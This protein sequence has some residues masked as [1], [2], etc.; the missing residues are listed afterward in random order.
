MGYASDGYERG[1]PF[2]SYLKESDIYLSQVQ[3]IFDRR[4]AVCHSCFE[5][6]CQLKL[7]S[8]DMLIRGANSHLPTG[9]LL[10]AAPRTDLMVTLEQQ[11]RGGFYSVTEG[12]SNSILVNVL[13][14]GNDKSNL[15][16]EKYVKPE[17]RMCVTSVDAF[18]KLDLQKQKSLG[19]PYYMAALSSSELKILMAWASSGS[20]TPSESTMQRL[21]QPKQPAVILAWE[22]FF[23][24]REWKARWTARYLYEHLFTAHFYFEQSPGEFYE[25]VRS[26]TSAPEKIDEITTQRPFDMPWMLQHNFYYRLRKVQSTI[27]DKQHFVYKINKDTMLEL[28]NLFWFSNW[29]GTPESNPFNFADKNPFVAFEHIP[30][31]ARY[32][33]MLKNAKMLLDMD[34]RSDNCHGNGAAG[35]LRDNF[36]FMFVKPESDVSVRYLDFFKHANQYLQMANTV[37]SNLMLNVSFKSNQ[38]K[39]SQIKQKYQKALFPNGFT[40]NDIWD[41]ENGTQMPF[42]TIMRHEENVSVHEGPWGPRP[43]VSLLLDY[44]SFERLYYNCVGLSTLFDNINDKIG[45]VLYLRDMGREAEEQLLSFIPEEL[46]EKVRAEWIQGEGRKHMYDA[47]K[48]SLKF[49]RNLLNISEFKIDSNDPYGS[50]MDYLLLKSGRF[51]KRVI[52]TNYYPTSQDTPQYAKLK[53]L[54]IAMSK[55]EV[56]G[57]GNRATHFP[58]ISYLIVKGENQSINYY[59]I[60]ANRFYEY[61]NYLKLEEPTGLNFGRIPKKDTMNIFPEVIANYPMKIYIVDETN[62]DKMISDM[63]SVKN[64]SDYVAFDKIYGLQ[65]LNSNFWNIIDHLQ[66][67]YIRKDIINN[68]SL[69]LHDY[70]VHDLVGSP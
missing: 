62:L 26:K 1:G 34:M 7:T 19:M 31:Q 59:T 27:V 35:P 61:V 38:E 60:I 25:L 54:S 64:R 16:V 69:D 42:F 13:L 68:G 37:F 46:R 11:R 32:R 29:N 55:E 30:A 44:V 50:L 56:K 43:R 17:D 45:T 41:G 39:Y 8:A 65:K 47:S 40:F 10:K 4:C 6:A 58:N 57:E 48:F 5:S 9:G 70:G 20:K 2:S 22:N 23:N 28:K 12:N 52:G 3:P 18:Q 49:N 33:W 21:A 14:A 51:S 53:A 24:N 63:K 36:L 15:P 66:T 67:Y